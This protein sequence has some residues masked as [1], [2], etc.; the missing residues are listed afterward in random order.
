MLCLRLVSEKIVLHKRN[1]KK[2][3]I[4]KTN[5]DY[6]LSWVSHINNTHAC[7][8]TDTHIWQIYIFLS[9]SFLI[10]IYVFLFYYFSILFSQQPNRD[11]RN[12]EKGGKKIKNRRMNFGCGRK[13]LISSIHSDLGIPFAEIS[14]YMSWNQRHYE[15]YKVKTFSFSLKSLL[16]F[17]LFLSLSLSEFYSASIPQ[18]DD[19]C[20]YDSVP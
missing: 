1:K 11:R 16:F 6:C 10:V 9:F 17:S 4:L 19:S 2:D 7:M 14:T 13:N 5:F 15:P 20:L 3:T 12:S 8:H 18:D